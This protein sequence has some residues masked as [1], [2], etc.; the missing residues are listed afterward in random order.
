M[1][2]PNR[3]ILLSHDLPQLII[4]TLQILLPIIVSPATLALNFRLVRSAFGALMNIS[5][6]HPATQ[7]AILELP[8]GVHALLAV[9]NELYLPKDWSRRPD[10]G[11]EGGGVDELSVSERAGVAMWGWKVIGEIALLE[12]EPPIPLPP[13]VLP[14]LLPSL[15]SYLPPSSPLSSPSISSSSTLKQTPISLSTDLQILLTATHLLSTQT[16]LCPAWEAS[17]ANLRAVQGEHQEW[18]FWEGELELWADEVEEDKEGAAKGREVLGLL[19][20]F[21]E[22]TQLPGE[23]EVELA[24][25][26]DEEDEEEE[27]G[28]VEGSAGRL[29]DWEKSMGEI[30]GGLVRTI[31]GVVGNDEVGK[32]LFDN[33]DAGGG[34]FVRKLGEWLEVGS[35]EREDL[36]VCAVLCLGN[37]ARN[38]ELLSSSVISF[39]R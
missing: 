25:D 30:K 11:G 34:W 9:V 37:L 18:D 27:E 15:F 4:N 7:R 23:E 32:T 26:D 39:I 31:V 35:T 29:K 5:L 21:V 38:G 16:T 19:M 33:D 13:S 12:S 10:R 8:S 20:D 2:D 14:L 36:V 1:T 6:D 24:A 22:F 3:T 17:L 28:S